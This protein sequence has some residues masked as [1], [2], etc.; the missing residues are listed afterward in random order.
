MIFGIAVSTLRSRKGGFLGAFVALVV[1][2]A[3]LAACGIL[4]ETGLRG[5][6]PT[7]RYA[8]T[9]IVVA[10][11]QELHFEKPRNGKTKTKTKPATE[12]ARLPETDLDLV[13]GVAGV[14]TAVPE[15]TFPA[16]VLGAPGDK[17][18]WGHAWESA[19]LT[20]FTL[21]AGRPPAATGEVVLDGAAKVRVGD[22]IMLQATAA[23]TAYT[24]VGVTTQALPRQGAVFF[25]DAEAR[26]L[27]GD[28]LT[29]IGVR[30]APGADA[31][32]LR[33]RLDRALPDAKVYTGDDRSVVEFRDAAAARVTLISMSGAVGATA[34]LVAILIVAGTFA[35]SIQ[36]RYAE[37]ALLRAVAA[38]PRQVRRI[39]SREALVV[40]TVAAALGAAAGIPLA[41]WLRSRFVAY[42][43][44]P[45][46]LGLV[47]GPVPLLGSVVVTVGAAWLASQGAARQASRIRPSAA[48]ANAEVEAHRISAPAAVGGGLLL[49]AGIGLMVLLRSVHNEPV[50]MPVALLTVV[51]CVS[52]LALLGSLIAPAATALLAAPLQLLPGTGGYLAAANIRANSRRLA[53]VVTPMTL[54]VAMATTVVFVQTTLN[55]AEQRQA[56]DGTVASYV[57]RGRWPGV[58]TEEAD[59]ARTT[60]GVTAVTEVLHSTVWIGKNRYAAQGVT[61]AGLAA[62]M[63]LG[64]RSGAIGQM[65]GDT[66]ALSATTADAIGKRVGGMLDL[67]L[68]DGAPATLRII[69]IYGRGLGFGALTLPYQLMTGHVTIPLADSVLIAAPPSARP[70]LGAL[71]QR[72]PGIELLDHP[73]AWAQAAKAKNAGVM[74]VA[75][76][77]IVAFAAIAIVNTLAMSIVDRRREFALLRLVGTTRRQVLRMLRAETIVVAAIGLVAGAAIGGCTL[78]AFATGMTGSAVPAAPPLWCAAIVAGAVLLAHLATAVP[79]RV[80]LR[81]EPQI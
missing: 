22:H 29:A 36:Q 77:L 48:L 51:A 63:D 70:A 19:A 38:T 13:R 1:A 73:S 66:V 57:L 46:S 76:G 15:V 4:L 78:A 61:P 68:G 58:P 11:D 64:V 71:A 6:V 16:A 14:G 33:E 69:A 27:A 50:A 9:P 30:P 18:S 60:P 55:Q 56:T 34:L 43:A 42:G 23:P 21:R 8:G 67:R 5:A 81:S 41:H 62:T 65:T 35:L 24:V 54:A 32:Q 79:A 39:L 49:A 17:P 10:A 26:K 53:A 44:V 37:I 72:Y 75:L 59:A 45:R 25:S 80:A 47:V 3:V 28:R 20:P 2:G 31:A 7:E 74:Y 12:T 52:G 40:G